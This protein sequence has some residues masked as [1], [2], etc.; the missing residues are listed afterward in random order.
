MSQNQTRIAVPFVVDDLRVVPATVVPTSGRAFQKNPATTAFRFKKGKSRGGK[1]AVSPWQ[2]RDRFL[3][4]P[5]EDWQR[6]FELSGEWDVGGAYSSRFKKED[7][8]EWQRLLRAAL[9]AKEWSTLDDKFD[10]LKIVSLKLPLAIS[11]E[12][13]GEIPAARI[14]SRSALESMIATVQLDKLQG[15]AFRLCA[16]PDCINPP[17]R[18]EARQKIYCSSDCAHLVAV[19]NSR[20]RAQERTERKRK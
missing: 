11:F 3:S 12:W 16:R 17:F 6:F 9:V 7:F 1:T 15:A 10:R 13:G 8:A 4:W 18:V 2:L 5:L 14:I 19:R 20:K